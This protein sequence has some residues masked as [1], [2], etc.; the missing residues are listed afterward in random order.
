[1]LKPIRLSLL[2]LCLLGLAYGQRFDIQT[3]IARIENVELVAVKYDSLTINLSEYGLTA[4][5]S[6]AEI[7]TIYFTGGGKPV[8]KNIL[9][10]MLV[11]GLAGLVISPLVLGGF[12]PRGG[13]AKFVIILGIIFFTFM[14]G[15]FGNLIGGFPGPDEIYELSYLDKG[16][17]IR[18]VLQI[19]A[20][21]QD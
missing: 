7:Q 15:L 14:G 11:G 8:T 12:F 9:I 6:I 13:T 17:K 16:E 21:Y 18:V 2:I 5:L 19:V 3:T 4:D 10:G 20:K 1:M